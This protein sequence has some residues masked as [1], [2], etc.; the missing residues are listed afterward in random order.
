[1]SFV[2]KN[3]K[4]CVNILRWDF[5]RRDGDYAA[6]LHNPPKSHQHYLP[7]G[8]RWSVNRRR[9]ALAALGGVGVG[10]LNGLLGAGGGMLTVP[11]LELLGVRGRRGHATSLAV[12][13]PLSLV[14]AALYWRR[15]WFSPLL[16]LPYLP[17]GLA[18]AMAGG[19]LLARLNTAWLKS[20]FSFLLLW[21]A[22]RLL[23]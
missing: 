21:A 5:G 1:M 3:C 11:L 13:L 4:P 18:G 9:T 23:K 10:F 7:K 12:I 8:R 15:G 22:F 20:A 19:L 14:S 17:G 6:V 2:K 16:A